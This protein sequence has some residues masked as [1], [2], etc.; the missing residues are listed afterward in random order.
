MI[1][2]LMILGWVLAWSSSDQLQF[3]HAVLGAMLGWSVGQLYVSPGGVPAR[4]VAAFIAVFI[5]SLVLH[6]LE[7]WS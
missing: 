7:R 2:I 6:F 1:P 3:V 4:W 5:F